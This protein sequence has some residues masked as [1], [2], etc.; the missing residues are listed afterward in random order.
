MSCP[1]A[2][3]PPVPPSTCNSVH[4]NSPP[5]CTCGIKPYAPIAV[6]WPGDSMPSV[7][8]GARVVSAPLLLFTSSPLTL[9]SFLEPLF[10]RSASSSKRLRKGLWAQ[11]RETWRPWHVVTWPSPVVPAGN[12]PPSELG[13]ARSVVLWCASILIV[14][15][16]TR[17]FPLRKLLEFLLGCLVF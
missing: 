14:W 16:V 4:A 11:T 17:F 15:W 9:N 6:T 13:R 10:I 7:F 5:G 8:C 2:P 3:C 1:F 12:R